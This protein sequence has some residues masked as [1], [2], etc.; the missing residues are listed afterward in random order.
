MSKQASTP[1]EIP[2]RV[3]IVFAVLTPLAFV[4]LFV[5]P[6]IAA[7]SPSEHGTVGVLFGAFM[8]L[9]LFMLVGMHAF[10]A[11]RAFY[12]LQHP[13]IFRAFRQP[14]HDRHPSASGAIVSMF[15]S[16][17]FLNYAFAVLYVFVASVD[18]AAFSAG[19][20]GAFEG[21]YFSVLTGA[22]VAFGDIVPKSTL[23]RAIVMTHITLSIAYVVLLFS[24]S[25]SY[26]AEK[27]KTPANA[28]DPAD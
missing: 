9:Q 15:L 1:R 18:P 27:R 28:D 13:R 17:A 25:S 3:K 21:W 22:T 14:L 5:V 24:A 11:G 10:E 2:T 4:Y 20:L 26:L 23:A 12:N 8:L 16:Y 6:M 19:R 7:L